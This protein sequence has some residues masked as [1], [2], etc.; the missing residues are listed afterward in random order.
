MSID[1][2][3]NFI[4]GDEIDKNLFRSSADKA[5]A[6]TIDRNG[7]TEEVQVTPKA[8]EA[9]DGSKVGQFG[10]TRILKNDILSILAYGFT[11]TV[12]V[13]VLVLSALGSLFTRV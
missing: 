4:P 8:V 5:L 2:V 6:V 10:V 11:Q 13:V 9:S 12:S 7:K 1:G 3:E